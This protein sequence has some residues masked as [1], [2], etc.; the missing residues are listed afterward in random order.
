MPT[1]IAIRPIEAVRV[2]HAG[3]THNCLR[4]AAGQLSGPYDSV[5]DVGSPAHSSGGH[6]LHGQPKRQ[7]VSDLDGVD[8]SVA[9]AGNVLEQLANLLLQHEVLEFPLA[10][11][12]VVPADLQLTH[13][14]RGRGEHRLTGPNGEPLDP[15][16]VD[17][18]HQLDQPPL[19][20]SQIPLA[21]LWSHRQLPCPSGT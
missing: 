13:Y 15:A 7:A 8:D 4:F 3:G 20:R 9:E 5:N 6:L 21:D 17:G 2:R 19:M 10:P 14:P 11:D 12:L 18:L 16:E 1:Q